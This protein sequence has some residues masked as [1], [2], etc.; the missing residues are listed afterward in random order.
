MSKLIHKPMDNLCTTNGKLV[1]GLG[2]DVYNSKVTHT[3]KNR[4]GGYT[5]QL[6]NLYTLLVHTFLG[7][8]NRSAWLLMH[9]FHTANNNYYINK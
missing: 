1:S 8:Y 2:Q 4:V 6:Q 7:Q 3:P 9:P 5:Q